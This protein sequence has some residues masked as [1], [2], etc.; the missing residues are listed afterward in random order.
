LIKKDYLRI[1]SQLDMFLEDVQRN[2][3][4]LGYIHYH[5][6]KSIVNFNIYGTEKALIEIEKACKIAGND[7][8]VISVAEYGNDIL[9]ILKRY[10]VIKNTKYI[11][12]LLEKTKQYAQCFGPSIILTQKEKQ[13][14][15]LLDNGLSYK[16]ISKELGLSISTV[17]K[18]TVSIY[19]KLD[20]KNKTLALKK[21]KILNIL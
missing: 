20:V 3:Y 11:N 19:K 5:V 14:F 10:R 16:K 13:V 17:N 2:N 18:H 9:P 1:D 6:I 15:I 4:Q 21:A 8:V 12:L 7:N